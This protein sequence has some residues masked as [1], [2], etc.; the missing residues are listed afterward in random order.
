MK[1][2]NMRSGAG[3]ARTIPRIVLVSGSPRR[4]ELLEQLGVSYTV[5]IP[6]VD[7]SVA[8]PVRPTSYVRTVVRRKIMTYIERNAPSGSPT[9]RGSRTPA[10]EGSRP[11]DD[12]TRRTLD[13]DRDWALAADTVVALGSRIIG[14]PVD[15]A[16][17]EQILRS[18]SGRSHRVITALALYN[19]HAGSIAV[20]TA[21]TRVTFGRLSEEE[22]EWYLRSGEWRDVA[23]GYRIQERGSVL[24]RKIVGSYSNVVGLPLETFYGM[25]LAQGFH[26]FPYRE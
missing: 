21:A 4:R 7:E 12:R 23:G 10:D 3:T 2:S 14:K 18:L 16:D 26:L 15:S 9:E 5:S 17:A 20:R 11:A 6:G 13:A 22:I 24:V 25:V 19:P 1:R 8:G